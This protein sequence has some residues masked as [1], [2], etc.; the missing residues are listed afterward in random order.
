MT[1][2][3]P[4]SS[5]PH[6]TKPSMRRVALITALVMLVPTTVMILLRVDIPLLG[7]TLSGGLL[8]C[9][10]LLIARTS[11]GTGTTPVVRRRRR[12]TTLASRPK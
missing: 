5:R 6:A 1:L 9:V 10:V 7:I 8:L 2:H 4:R 12:D 11:F 3:P